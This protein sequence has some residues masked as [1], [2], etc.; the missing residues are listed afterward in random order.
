MA[1]YPAPVP[2]TEEYREP[3]SGMA[4]WAAFGGFMMIVLGSL[5]AIEGLFALIRDQA[6][7]VSQAGLTIWD[8]TT[9]GW[10][11]RGLGIVIALAGMSVLAGN[12]FGRIIGVVAVGLNLIAQFTFMNYHPVWSLTLIALDTV[13]IYALI[14]HGRELKA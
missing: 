1:T 5:A 10:I 11:H 9:W 12:M 14:A 13:I 7:V 8:L 6:F 4:G 3:V 2:P